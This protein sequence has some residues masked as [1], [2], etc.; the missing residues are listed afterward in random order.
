MEVSLTD[1]D[2]EEVKKV[3][4]AVI[5][6]YKNG[7]LDA[8]RTRRNARLDELDHIADKKRDEVWTRSQELRQLAETLGTSDPETVRLREQMAMRQFGDIQSQHSQALIAL[9]RARGDL[10]G[11]RTLLENIDA[12]PIPELD[13][14]DYVSRHPT[15][16]QLS[17]SLA[18]QMM[19]LAETQRA[20]R[21]DA[22][23]RLTARYTGDVGTI[24]SQIAALG[25]QART[26]LREKI[27]SEIEDQIRQLEVQVEVLSD[28]EQRL[29]E[30]V[31]QQETEIG[32]LSTT[33]IDLQMVQAEID[34]SNEVLMSVRD[35]AQRM[36]VELN[37]DP[38]VQL[39]QEPET[40]KSEDRFGIRVALTVLASIVGLCIPIGSITWWDTRAERINSVDD[41]S[42]RL[43]LTVLG[44]VPRIPARAVRELGSASKNRQTWHL[45][46]TESID[47]IA[48]R[49]LHQADVKQTRVVLISSASGGEGKTT[50][51]TQL[52]MS[53]AR[54]GRRTALVDFDLR[55]PAFDKV[56]GLPLEPGVSEVLRGQNEASEVIHPTGTENLDVV[57]A[58]RWDR[59]ALTA[60]ANGAAGSLFD[61]LRAKYDFVVVDTAPILPVADTR[62][63]S[64][65]ADTVILSV[66]RDI[67]RSPK[68]MAAVETLDAFGVT[69]VEAVVTGPTDNLPDKDLRYALSQQQ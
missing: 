58:G 54:N 16:R 52:A 25:D 26:K 61:V 9:E 23:D 67:S 64:Q 2:G 46:L 21:S 34:R 37:S 51:A 40:P 5:D 1:N 68:I 49:L 32:K 31:T 7:V 63:V 62:F 18:G 42:K 41:V 53:L 47:G 50:L 48:A 4:A 10:R 27:R 55:R 19:A 44:S 24:E 28:Q 39:V 43:G 15:V 35:E 12:V 13:V 56:L 66:F 14:E 38:R 20:V 59:L 6:A 36:R 33:S 45:R 69:S 11:Q 22:P 57:T 17:D 3:V 65:H 29:A 60:L 8:E 30:A